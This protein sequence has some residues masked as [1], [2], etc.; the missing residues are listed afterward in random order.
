[1]GHDGAVPARPSS[2]SPGP[3]D[4]DTGDTGV[5]R[6]FLR[7]GST[8]FGG[9]VAHLGFFRTEFVGRRRWL[10]EA[11]YADLVAL[12]QFL[13]GP[14]SSQVGMG[15]GLLRSGIPGSLRAWL[16]FTLPSA[17]LLIGA[18]M[19][20]GSGVEVPGGVA[21]GLKV[22]AVAV[23]AQAVVLMARSLCRGVVRAAV[24]V[25]SA[26][27]I[28]AVPTVWMPSVVLALA[29]AVGLLLLRDVEGGPGTAGETSPWPQLPRWVPPAAVTLFVALLFGLPILARLLPVEWL[30]LVAGFYRAGALVFGGGH[31][32]LPMLEE[33]VV[34]TGALTQADFVAG[35]G[36]AN[37]VPGP[38]F[39]FAGYLGATV[40]GP[41]LGI[42][43]L[44]AIF[45]PGWLLVVAA[46]GHWHRLAGQVR[47]RRALAAVNAAVVGLLAAALYDPVWTSAVTG[48]VELLLAC[49]AF[50]ALVALRVAPHLVV[51]GC[52]ASGWILL[53]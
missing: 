24:A 50:V 26:V 3:G 22:A 13:P 16:G 5:G 42:V 33:V 25:L 2:S 20:V 30:V 49:A 14:A 27:A 53:G 4:T 34:G 9:P 10:G 19:A 28:L 40:G 35:Y 17:V 43:A 8:S 11:Q 15:I 23:V 47:V 7:L 18:G 46:L 37:A 39:T 38:L 6:T 44:V 29:G 48:W 21:A 45:L 32:V 12:A 41:V 52:A 51:L 36:L 1:M 31:V